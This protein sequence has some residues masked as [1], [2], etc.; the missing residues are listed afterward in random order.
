MKKLLRKILR[1]DTEISEYSTVTVAGEIK[2]RVFL[3]SG[4]S[5]IDISTIHWLLCLEPFVFGVW[6][7]KEEQI[8]ELREAAGFS[9]YFSDSPVDDF[10]IAKRNAL[11]I[12]TLEYL[13]AVIELFLMIRTLPKM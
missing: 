9:M 1:G 7:T 5:A 2:E 11:A 3:E 4:K 13:M 10:K 8:I 12:I 6:L